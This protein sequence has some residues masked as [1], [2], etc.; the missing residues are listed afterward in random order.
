MLPV[1]VSSIKNKMD[2]ALYFPPPHK[3]FFCRYL[4]GSSWP[5]TNEARELILLIPPQPS[6]LSKQHYGGLVKTNP[7]N[8]M[9]CSI[10]DLFNLIYSRQV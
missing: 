3:F 4:V 5:S 2:S 1:S 9:D 10:S 8:A 6:R 7:E